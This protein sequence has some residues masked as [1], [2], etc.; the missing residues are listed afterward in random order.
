MPRPRTSTIG[1]AP[2]NTPATGR[3]RPQ[4]DPHAERGRARHAGRARDRVREDPFDERLEQLA[5]ARSRGRGACRA[6]TTCSTRRAPRRIVGSGPMPPSKIRGPYTRKKIVRM[7]PARNATPL[8]GRR[9]ERLRRPIRPRAACGMSLT[10]FVHALAAAGSDGRSSEFFSSSAARVGA[11]CCNECVAVRDVV[12]EA[13]A[14]E[15]DRAEPD[16]HDEQHDRSA[17]WTAECASRT[18]PPGYTSAAIAAAT[19]TQAMTRSE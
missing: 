2:T 1:S 17:A 3:K 16:D 15:A 9:L 5:Y 4:P 7:S 13:V 12:H 8:R 18:R 14:D 19:S 6:S 10:R 11:A